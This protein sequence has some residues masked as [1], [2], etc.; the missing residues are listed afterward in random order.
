[1]LAIMLTPFETF[2][3]VVV[4]RL[5]QERDHLGLMSFQSNTLKSS[6]AG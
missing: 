6:G 2:G 5:D 3:D 4:T 1:M